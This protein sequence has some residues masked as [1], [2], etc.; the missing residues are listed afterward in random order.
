MDR[1]GAARGVRRL[2]QLPFQCVAASATWRTFRQRLDIELSPLLLTCAKVR[3]GGSPAV[4]ALYR[5][6][7]F[8]AEAVL[9]HCSPAFSGPHHQRDG[10]HRNDGDHDPYQGS[11]RIFLLSE[12]LLLPGRG[13]LNGRRRGGLGNVA[14]PAFEDQVGVPLTWLSSCRAGGWRSRAAAAGWPRRPG[15]PPARR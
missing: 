1:A 7:V 11:Y 8:R 4:A 2:L 9:E 12:L 6:V 5:P 3:L 13:R 15:S 10:G 14:V